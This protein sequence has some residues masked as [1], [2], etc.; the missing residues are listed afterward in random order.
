[1]SKKW[2][3]KQKNQPVRILAIGLDDAEKT[4]LQ[5]YYEN[6]SLELFFS[7]SDL[8]GWDH[9]DHEKFDLC[10]VGQ[11]DE[12]QDMDYLAW[13]LKDAMTPSRLILIISKSTREELKHLRKYRIR[14]ILQRPLDEV[15]FTRTI[16]KALDYN[17]PWYLRLAQMFK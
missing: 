1:M 3:T 11:G 7:Q 8:D 12:N 4:F 14:Y 9:A 17:K 13:L 2:K 6:S 16:E 5:D 15:Q 10:I